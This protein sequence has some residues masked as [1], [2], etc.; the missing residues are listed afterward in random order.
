MKRLLS[1][2]WPIRV[3]ADLHSLALKSVCGRLAV[4]LCQ[5]WLRDTGGSGPS[6]LSSGYF[7]LSRWEFISECATN[8]PVR[9]IKI[10]CSDLS[11]LPEGGIHELLPLTGLPAIRASQISSAP[12]LSQG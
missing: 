3:V 11:N 2:I 10:Y 12:G 5:S 9:I 8:A 7:S 1:R 6:S 4:N